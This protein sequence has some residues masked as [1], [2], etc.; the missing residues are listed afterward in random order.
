[1]RQFLFYSLWTDSG[2]SWEMEF[3]D[4][5]K[6]VLSQRWHDL[7]KHIAPW[8]GCTCLDGKDWE[9]CLEEKS[10][11]S[12]NKSSIFTNWSINLLLCLLGT[13]PSLFQW[14][15]MGF[16][17]EWA[18]HPL[19]VQ[20][21]PGEGGQPRPDQSGAPHHYGYGNWFRMGPRPKPESLF[22]DFGWNWEEKLAFSGG[23]KA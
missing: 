20:L 23:Y 15:H 11:M 1:M 5:N 19:S 6:T 22:H 10:I 21:A 2:G 8:R 18:P 16:L 13:Y 4:R 12:L 14:Q 3:Q 9:I 7:N 17:W